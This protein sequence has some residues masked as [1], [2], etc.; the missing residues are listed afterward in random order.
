MAKI[1]KTVKQECGCEIVYEQISRSMFIRE[2][3]GQLCPAHD[4]E[5]KAYRA[6]AQRGH[7]I[8]RK[9]Q[10]ERDLREELA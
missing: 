5:E 10:R 6:E 9:E 7:E 1:V 2:M 4:A 8:R 3:W